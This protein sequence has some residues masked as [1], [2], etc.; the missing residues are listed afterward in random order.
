VVSGLFA[1]D[2]TDKVVD[3][4]GYGQGAQIV[5]NQAGNVITGSV[6][7]TNYFT[8]S[9]DPAT[10]IVTFTQLNNIWHSNTGSDDETA[11]LTLA[12]ANLL[13]VI[14]SVTIATATPTRPTS[15]WALACSRSRTM[16]RSPIRSP[17]RSSAKGSTPT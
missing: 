17:S 11:T 5:L 10:G 8:I 14:Q 6:G 2:G 4:D 16:G 7:A 13:R 12:N 3:G 15:T 9:I 1:L